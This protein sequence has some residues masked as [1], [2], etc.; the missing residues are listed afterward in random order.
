MAQIP[1]A[2]GTTGP[3]PA[4]YYQ[5]HVYARDIHSGA[6]NCVCGAVVGSRRHVQVSVSGSGPV[7]L[8]MHVGRTIPRN[9]GLALNH[10]GWLGQ[11]GT[12]YALDDEPHGPREP[13]S[14][15]PL[16]MQIGTWE[17]L[18]DGHYAIKD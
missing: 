10:V 16:L 8:P 2:D 9:P 3:F 15:A 5:P 14:Y 17:D 18:G 1:G 6:G 12:V 13:G 4:Q 11:S 7:R